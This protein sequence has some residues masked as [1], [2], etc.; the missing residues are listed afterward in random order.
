MGRL[1]ASVRGDI[2]TLLGVPLPLADGRLR[3]IWVGSGEGIRALRGRGRGR[4]CEAG[5]EAGVARGAG[6]GGVFSVYV[7]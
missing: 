3:G 5:G 7:G 4:G 6:F 2:T 1:V